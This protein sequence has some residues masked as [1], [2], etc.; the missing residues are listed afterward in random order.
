MSETPSQPPSQEATITSGQNEYT[1]HGEDGTRLLQI[2]SF[3]SMTSS[4][5]TAQETLDL[6]RFLQDH[7]TQIEVTAL[8]QSEE[9]N[10]RKKSIEERLHDLLS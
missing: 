7:R 2:F 9:M 6:L 1:F 10:T 8:Q 4:Y 5:H 3:K